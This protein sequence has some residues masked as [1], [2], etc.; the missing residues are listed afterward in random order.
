[1]KSAPEVAVGAGLFPAHPPGRVRSFGESWAT[2]KQE[3]LR[4]GYREV[5][6]LKQRDVTYGFRCVLV[7]GGER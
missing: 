4:L 2:S 5:A 3:Y 7:P 6:D 1:M